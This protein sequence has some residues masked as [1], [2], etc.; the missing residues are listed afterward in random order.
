[1]SDSRQEASPERQKAQ[2]LP[3]CERKG[4]RVVG[5]YE[6]LGIPGD[7]FSRR[8]S[9]HRVLAD[10]KAGKLDV[11]VCDE[12][13]RLSRQEVMEFIATVLHP[14]KQAG[15]RVDTVAQGEM[16]PESIVGLITVALHQDRANGETKTLA[17]RVLTG[18]LAKAAQGVY[19]G[20]TAPYGYRLEP[21]PT[22]GK[23]KVIDERQAAVVRL[24]FD[25]IDRGHTR[26]GVCDELFKRGVP[27]RKGE[28]RWSKP[29]INKIL[30]NRE[31]VGDS[32]WGERSQAK[33]AAHS[34][35]QVIPLKKDGRKIRVNPVEDWV[36]RP[37]DHPAIVSRDQYERV[38]RKLA[39]NRTRTTPI[40]DG[41]PF[42]L[43]KLLVCGSCGYQMYGMTGRGVR[44]YF[45]GGWN[46][47]GKEFCT[48]N[49]VEQGKLLKAIVSTL[50]NHFLDAGRLQA[51]REEVRRQ[52]MAERESSAL[53][54]LRGRVADL[55]AKIKQGNVNLTV[56]PADMLQGVIANV[57]ELQRERAAAAARLAELEAGTPPT[58]EL[59]G[60]IARIESCLWNLGELIDKADPVPL[61]AAIREMVSKVTLNFT[62]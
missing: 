27:T 54:G 38:Q 43:S 23:V 36:I 8:D 6:D 52:E 17:R 18:A 51:L 30:K 15:V 45:C 46:N 22:R 41:G 20:G 10:A 49:G 37:D 56:L 16:D 62:R 2:V 50:R 13:S 4:Y 44:Y 28:A 47:F 11:I 29:T 53:D 32:T 25:M 5:V 26:H 12:W 7:E 31:Y 59:E 3:Y 21:H 55:D 42:V 60:W 39:G 40:Q 9:L 14:L 19:L 58:E 57:R 24:I 1:M 34:K 33:H 61:R 48:R 35:G